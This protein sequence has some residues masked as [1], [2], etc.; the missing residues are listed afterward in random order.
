M[1]NK[2]NGQGG[3]QD[4]MVNKAEPEMKTIEELAKIHQVP[5]WIMAGLQ[6]AYNWGSGKELTEEEFLRAKDK[7]LGGPMYNRRD[8]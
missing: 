8:K 1:T 4:E 6:I 3:G 2:R 7:W 5:D